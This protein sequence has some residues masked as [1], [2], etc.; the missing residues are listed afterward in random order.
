MTMLK[1]LVKN[2]S[3]RGGLVLEK[4]LKDCLS[5]EGSHAGAGEECR[6]SSH[7]GGRSIK[8]NVTATPI[9]HCP[10]L[11][12]GRR[13]TIQ[14]WGWDWEEGKSGGRCFFKIQFYF[15]S[16]THLIGNILFFLKL[17]LFHL[18][19][20]TDLSLSW[21]WPMSFSLYFLFLYSWGRGVMEQLWWH[22]M[23]SQHKQTTETKIKFACNVKI[24]SVD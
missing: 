13:L 7:W 9:P 20:Q 6:K 2:C 14:E 15:S 18:W 23:S 19:L 22:M 8:V 3:L 16:Y 1:K 10:A 21:C 5:W 11:V 12:E 24:L 17:S 4:L